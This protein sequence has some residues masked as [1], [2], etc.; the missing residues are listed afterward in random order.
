MKNLPIPVGLSRQTLLLRVALILLAVLA[1]LSA[2]RA[3]SN[4]ATPYTF[5][6]LAGNAGHGTD[7]GT[8]SAAQFHLS[9][10]GSEVD[11]AGVAVDSVGNIYVADTRNFTIRKITSGGV[12]TTLAG[13]A[14]SPGSADGTGSAARFDF[15]AGLA[16]DSAGNVYVADYLS[17][18]I[19]K[20]TSDGVVTTLAGSAFGTGSADGTG[21]AAQFTDPSGVAVDSAGNVYV[22]DQGNNT[23][24]KITSGGVVTTLAGLAGSSGST[25]GTGSAA[26][27]SSP[28][29]VGVDSA[30][31]VYVG[32]NG[33]HDI[34]KIT[35]SGV[36]T[37]LVAIGIPSG[38]AA[39]LPAGVAVD[40]AGNLYVTDSGNNMILKITSGGGVTTLAGSA[41]F[42]GSVDGTGSAAWFK[43]P[44]G[45]A[46]DSAGNVYVADTGNNTIR[47]ITGGG[48][49]TTLAGLAGSLGSADGTGN[50]ARFNAP[51]GV[52]V[53]SAGN[54][55]VADRYNDTIRKITSSGV[56]T[57]LAGVVGRALTGDGPGSAAGFS[58]PGGIAVDSAGN[59]YVAD[60]GNSTIRKITSGGVVTTLA[61][62]AGVTGSAD[63]TGSAARF[64][65]PSG[66]AVDSAGNV[67]VADTWNNTIRKITSAGVVTT[68]A[69]LPGS[70]QTWADGTGSAARFDQP[71]GI[72]V[73]SAGNIY[74]A[75]LLNDTIRKITSGG[76]VTT[77]A[78]LVQGGGGTLGWNDGTGIA[79]EFHY[80]SGVAVD[81]AGNVFVADTYNS[82]IRKI[83][84]AGVVT[85]I[86]G[87]FALYY[88]TYGDS[89]DATG[90]FARF[91]EPRGMAVDS[92]GKIY[93]ADTGNNTVRVGVP[94]IAGFYSHDFNGDG[95]S[96]LLWTDT[97]TG[98]RSIWLM[99]GTS[100]GSVVPLG[101]LSTDW[102][103]AGTGEFNFYGFTDILLQNTVTGERMVWLMNGTEHTSSVSLGIVSTDWQIAGTGD[104]NGDG[105]TDIVFQNTVTGDRSVWLMYYGTE[106][107]SAV[108]L[109]NVPIQWRIAGTGDFNGDGHTD[110]LWENTIT[111][112]RYIWL[113]NG[114]SLSSAVFL[115]N[116]P[117]QWR[118]AEVGDFNSDGQ[119]DI[120]FQNTVTGERTIWLM[121]G[122]TY[123]S[124]VSLGIMSLDWT[125]G[126]PFT[127]TSVRADFNADG[128]PD[129]VWENTTTGDRYVWLMNGTTFTSSVFIGNVGT[130]WHI[131]GTGDFNG[132]GKPDLVFEN[133]TTGDRYVWLMNGTTFTS[134]VYLGNVSTQ[135]RIVGVD[136]FNSDGKPDLI[137]ENTTTGDRYAWLMDGTTFTSAVFLGNVGTQWHIAGT[138]DFN[139]DGKPD[140]IFENTSTGDRYVWF[141]NGT[142]YTGSAYLGGLST[143]WH[144]AGAADFNADG[145]TDLIFENTTTG[146]RY[147]WL[148]NG[149]AFSSAVY[150]GNVS[151]QWQIKN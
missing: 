78:G 63:G 117:V 81:S 141:M 70:D 37:T 96:D 101:T 23:I 129:L 115:G 134:A 54:L 16:V 89:S 139:A 3:Q 99:N 2:L 133:T 142:T 58:S 119:S 113:M 53:D 95:K 60:Y 114:T 34:R 44:T 85:T 82:E 69:G 35:S 55:Y 15:P 123:M 91:S 19:R 21:S 38:G 97:V 42:T 109:G 98:E 33:N 80:P 110:L 128:K 105:Q 24:R 66:V 72:A 59:L 62:S 68:L 103:F 17:S 135:W 76:V 47:K 146:D 10:G 148:M 116:V 40:S 144:I 45:I 88:D 106:L 22:A 49:V 65:N 111:G 26:R 84:P 75:D 57:T 87:S 50:A 67:Y 93:V 121:N 122:T 126:L 1:S 25:N 102:Q 92:T 39:F 124:A 143:A 7:D 120:V 127:T 48:L 138:G 18:T 36:V 71:T 27:F 79:A 32:E 29:S 86:A 136:D 4:F 28:G 130:A 137:F 107:I 31:N 145:H 14:G 5:T 147:F 12:V 150:L 140:L 20:I 64:K 151:T 43:D 94:S 46:V 11:S 41:H 30:G 74:V 118:I 125:I 56:V 51:W 9:I 112:D 6:T 61:G 13:L 52:A 73:D 132:D 149:T 100:L 104:F 83:T 108:S 8:G 90:A 131:A 77:L